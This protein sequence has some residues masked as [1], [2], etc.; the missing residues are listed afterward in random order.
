MGLQ[1][2]RQLKTVREKTSRSREKIEGRTMC[3]KKNG[4]KM[5]AKRVIL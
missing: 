5:K 4:K 2:R 1:E 3:W